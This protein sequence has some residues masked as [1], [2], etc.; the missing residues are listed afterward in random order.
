MSER[1]G[2]VMMVLGAER[3]L[4]LELPSCGPHGSA[5]ATLIS[6][7]PVT[8][9]RTDVKDCLRL[10]TLHY[11]RRI[12]FPCLQF[13]LH[14]TDPRSQLV[15]FCRES[16]LLLPTHQNQSTTV[17][18]RNSHLSEPAASSQPLLLPYIVPLAAPASN[19]PDRLL[20]SRSPFLSDSPGSGS[21]RP[22]AG[23]AGL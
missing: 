7:R 3:M 16:S 12:P 22:E 1:V 5:S 14:I 2:L 8:V 11:P 6:S 19:S 10:D 23:S 9:L 21:S 4:E 17:I 13:D 18:F 15:G 20:S